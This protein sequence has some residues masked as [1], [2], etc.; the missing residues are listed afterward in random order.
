MSP[1]VDADWEG[2]NNY[3]AVL[4]LV[5]GETSF[6]VCVG[7]GANQRV[8]ALHIQILEIAGQAVCVLIL[9]G[10]NQHVADGLRAWAQWAGL[11]CW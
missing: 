6:M 10:I 4:R 11:F 3:S 5:Y 1:R 7:V 2:A 9:A 8:N